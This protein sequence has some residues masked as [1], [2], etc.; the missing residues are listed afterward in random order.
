VDPKLTIYTKMPLALKSMSISIMQGMDKLRFKKW[1]DSAYT[2]LMES[3]WFSRNELLE[4]QFQRLKKLLIYANENVPYYNRV[5]KRFGVMPKSMNDFEIMK[6]I[7]F[8]TKDIIRRN[9]NELI[10]TNIPKSQMFH[11]HTSGTTGSP[12]SFY[13]DLRTQG[14]Y[15]AHILR[16]R[17]WWGFNFK[18]YTASFGGKTVIPIYQTRPPFWVTDIPDKLIIFSSFHLKPRFMEYMIEY[19]LRTGIKAIKGY[20]SN[21]YILAQYLK[22]RNAYLPMKFVFTGAEPVYPYM[23]SL[24][25]ERFKCEVSD[26]YGNSEETARAYECKK[27]M[28]H[29]AMESIYLEIVNEE[30]SPCKIG[31]IGEIVGTSLTN[32]A[33]P[34]IRYK[35]GDL[36]SFVDN[37]DCG[38]SLPVISQVTTKV[39]D[40]ILSKDSRMVSPSALTHPFKPLDP[41]AVLKS[42]IIQR[43][44]GKITVKIVKGPGFSSAQEEMLLRNF[45]ERFGDLLTVKIEFVDEIPK[46]ANGKYRWVISDLTKNN[47]KFG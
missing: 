35:T 11:S 2:E 6:K 36:S 44:I 26:F 15:R 13:M 1:V 7:P 9:F 31:E 4:L 14:Y 33:M 34:F 42:Q 32:Y 20:P 22:S 12:L 3:Q 45:R 37:C 46:T 25:E 29:I 47:L 21:L 41:L 8:L 18:E 5:F 24:I 19:I 28:C 40:I 30:G 10:S 43:K 39:E 16:H 23:R 38:L 17:A 27:H